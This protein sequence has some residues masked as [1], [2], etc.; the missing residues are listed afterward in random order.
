MNTLVLGYFSLELITRVIN[1][2]KIIRSAAHLLLGT[3]VMLASL[4]SNADYKYSLI[5]WQKRDQLIIVFSDQLVRFVFYIGSIVFSWCIPYMYAIGS[6]NYKQYC[7][8]EL[9]IEHKE[10][11]V[12][13]QIWKINHLCKELKL[14]LDIFQEQLR[15]YGFVI[16]DVLFDGLFVMF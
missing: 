5:T 3:T 8:I 2:D 15:Q 13:I 14:H 10:W 4:I 11:S 9:I 7:K 6:G 12:N 16:F 1:E